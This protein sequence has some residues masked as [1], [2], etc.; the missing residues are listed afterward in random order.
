MVLE[1]PKKRV[2]IVD[3]D[4]DL[5]QILKTAINSMQCEVVGEGVDGGDAIR[6][7]R[8]LRPDLLM[9]DVN[10]PAVSGLQALTGIRTEFPDAFIVMLTANADLQT[11]KECIKR[12]AARYI[13]KDTSVARIRVM[14]GEAL[15]LGQG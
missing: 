14:V 2:V 3:D 12:G 4:D 15:G 9:L 7:Y 1:T 13:L 5:R 8:D 10:M 6:L 11:V